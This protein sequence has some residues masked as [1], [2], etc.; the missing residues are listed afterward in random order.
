MM[1]KAIP[2]LLILLT[3]GGCDSFLGDESYSDEELLALTKGTTGLTSIGSSDK[4]LALIRAGLRHQSGALGYTNIEELA[5][6]DATAVSADGSTTASATST[7]NLQVGGVD[8]ADLMKS[9]GSLLYLALPGN[10]NTTVSVVEPLSDDDS[11]SVATDDYDGYMQKNRLRIF[12]LT[13]S[14]PANQLLKELEVGESGDP[15]LQGIYLLENQRIVLLYGGGGGYWSNW[16]NPWYWQQSSTV[17]EILDLSDLDN[18]QREARIELDGHLVASRR[19]DNQLYLVDRYTPYIEGYIHYSSEAGVL[20]Q[21]EALLEQINLADLIP[22]IDTGS[23]TTALVSADSCYLPPIETTDQFSPDIVTLLSIDLQQPQQWQSRCLLGSTETLYMSTE[24]AYLATS[25]SSYQM[26]D[27]VSFY[28][29]E[30][31][32]DIHKFDLTTS[33]LEY[34]GSG[35]VSGHIGWE[36][37][38]K[39]FRMGENQG[40]LGVV[41]S[42]GESWNETSSTRLTLLQEGAGGSLEMVST[43]GALGHPGERLYAA[44]FMGERLYL[45]TFQVTDPLYIIDI[46]DP[47]TLSS[48]DVGEL[49]LP[50]YSDYLHPL[51]NG[52]LLGVGKDAIADS[53]GDGRG[54]WYQGVKLTLFDVANI[55][56]PS[57]IDSMVIG[58]RG[59]NA[60]VNY[61]HHGFIWL[62]ADAT[63]GRLARLALPIQLHDG[64]PSYDSGEPWAWYSWSHTGLYQFEIDDGLTSG[65]PAINQVGVVIAESSSGE[66]SWPLGSI[67]ND[68]G[69]ISEDELHY[70]HNGEVIS[71]N[72]GDSSAA[73]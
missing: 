69:V 26:D 41:T 31:Q 18:P 58:N 68:R 32:T 43:L 7:T 25:L 44:R 39:P 50:G 35:T 45:V 38:K 51:P 28:S 5:V 3:L 23:G 11:V 65:T 56:Q 52:M 63:Q 22:T 40:V 62:G 16:W 57:L 66:Q 47:A 70:V 72:W 10:T 4:M 73:P 1:H 2:Y 59:T 53:I 37:D 17:V 13:S 64:T 55:E 24:S 49:E 60:T 34:R 19:I 9:D 61:D 30:W 21:N 42:E 29:N 33:N 71:A 46:S 36:V 54:A 48:A 15:L 6:D 12:S 8:E 20:S 14:P 27:G 67:Y